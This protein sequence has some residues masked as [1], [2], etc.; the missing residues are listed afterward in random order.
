MS[1]D[2]KSKDLVSLFEDEGAMGEARSRGEKSLDHLTLDQIA[3]IRARCK[4]DLMFLA[5][6]LEYDLLSVPFHGHMCRWLEDT[7]DVQK[8]ELLA[9]RG[10]YKS[11][12]ATVTDGIQISLPDEA[13][14]GLH[15]YSLGPNV[16]LLIVHEKRDTAA[17]FLFEIAMAF[18]RKSTFMALWP[19]LIP[20]RRV[21]RMNKWELELPRTEHHKE[22]TFSAAGV[23]GAEQGYHFHHIKFD[24][25]VG[26]EAR[27]SDVVMEDTI[28][29]FDNA[30]SLLTRPKLDGWELIGTRWSG[31]DLYDHAE[32][33]FGIDKPRSFV[34]NYKPKK[35]SEMKEGSMALYGRS[36]VEGGRITF[37]EEFP[38]QIVKELKTANPIIWAAQYV[39]DP[40][41][42]GLNQFKESWRRYYNRGRGGRL[43]VFEGNDYWNVY[44]SELDIVLLMDPSMGRDKGADPSAFVVTGTSKRGRVFILETIKARLSPPEFM[45]MW[46]KLLLKWK[47]RVSSIEDVAFQ[48]VMAHWFEDKCAKMNLYPAVMPYKTGG[49]RKDLRVHALSYYWAAGIIYGDPNMKELWEEYELFPQT[50]DYHLLDALAQGIERWAEVSSFL[51]P[52]DAEEAIHSAIAASRFERSRV[53]GY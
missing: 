9:P 34:R 51:S 43:I 13:G 32:R 23:G 11:T 3:Q 42:S 39:N 4:N 19:E 28:L 37:P 36:V 53:T 18:A 25:L 22:A 50:E 31:N 14:V 49:K 20:S 29:F 48:Y 5:T 38:E 17:S 47:P 40:S 24:D 21:H 46:F 2:D 44:T 12:I 45:N 33:R 30:G 1:T 41:E 52:E 27:K 8:R 15:P 26:K 10:H 6:I 16:K 7:R 35:V